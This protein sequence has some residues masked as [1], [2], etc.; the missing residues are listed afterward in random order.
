M[1]TKASL[2]SPSLYLEHSVV[3]WSLITDNMGQIETYI[4]KEIVDWCEKHNQDPLGSKEDPQETESIVIMKG[5][6]TPTQAEIH[7]L[8]E[9][10]RVKILMLLF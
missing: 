10:I 9:V 2:A 7:K 6:K 4:L 1:S 5:T 3:L 8:F